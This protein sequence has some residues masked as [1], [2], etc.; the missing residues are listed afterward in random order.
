MSE[1]KDSKQK[2]NI[3][4]E[5]N[6]EFPA[7]AETAYVSSVELCRLFSQFMKATF[8]DFEGVLFEM[9]N[10][11]PSISILFNHGN[12]NSDELVACERGCAV[13][14]GS[15]IIDRTRTRDR[16]ITEG[17]RYRLTEDGKEYFGKLLL[18]RLY[19]NGKPDWRRLVVEWVDRT[20]ANYYN[21]NLPQYTKISGI[22]I[23]KVCEVLYGTK[24]E[25][26]NDRFEYS[27]AVTK[28]TPGGMMYGNLSTNYMLNI[29]KVSEKEVR[30]VYR[31][32]GFGDCY[33][34]IIR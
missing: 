9:G 2:L 12:Y 15:S 31:D 3:A 10:G 34:H 13:N 19:N 8:A 33:S 1:N 32:M 20:Q 6:V 14:T 24:S 23:E 29:T 28:S 21:T 17:D 7:I 16:Q 25:D 5:E 26:S 18:R 22:S 11:E 30:K 4:L 27:V